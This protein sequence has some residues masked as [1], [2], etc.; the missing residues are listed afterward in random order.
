M[1]GEENRNANFKNAFPT[2][3]FIELSVK[4]EIIV[5]QSTYGGDG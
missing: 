1:Q 5:E 3:K 2:V 4:H